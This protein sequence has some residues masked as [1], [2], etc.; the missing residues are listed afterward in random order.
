V[1][2]KIEITLFISFISLILC[3]ILANILLYPLETLYRFP[4]DY[5]GYVLV[6]S[7]LV[8]PL[9]GAY[10]VFCLCYS[11]KLYVKRVTS[12]L[13]VHALIILL[14]YIAAPKH[15]EIRC[16][17]RTTTLDAAR[18]ELNTRENSWW[19]RVKISGRQ[20]QTDA[21]IKR[22]IVTGTT[23]GGWNTDLGADYAWTVAPTA[24]GGTISYQYGKRGAL[25][26]K[27]ATLKS[28]ATW[29]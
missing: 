24:S 4:Y 9:C 5:Q 7:L 29:H 20:F 10:V 14:G 27:A 1:K 22:E 15:M 28:P 17:A 12:A 8:F 26:R 21:E 23:G 16:C 19:A 3:F 18:A 13:I 2:G 6:F 25:T 11:G